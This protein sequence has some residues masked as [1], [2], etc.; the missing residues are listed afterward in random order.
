MNLSEALLHQ[1]F[2]KIFCKILVF[3]KIFCKILVNSRDPLSLMLQFFWCLSSFFKPQP[4]FSFTWKLFQLF[5]YDLIF[6]ITTKIIAIPKPL[7]SA[8]HLKDWILVIHPGFFFL[9]NKYGRKQVFRFIHNC[10][11]LYVCTQYTYRYMNK[12][13]NKNTVIRTHAYTY[14]HIHILFLLRV[15]VI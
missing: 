5:A 7:R 6:Q 13:T 10:T 2:C 12:H 15:S 1:I 3:T 11:E 9:G 8:C 4:Q 14:I